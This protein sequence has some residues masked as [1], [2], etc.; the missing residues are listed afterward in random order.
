MNAELTRQLGDRPVPPNAATTTPSLLITMRPARAGSGNDINAGSPGSQ[1][2][3]TRSP[4]S[5]WRHSARI[6]EVQVRN[7]LAAGGED[8]EPSIPHLR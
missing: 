7:G 2:A 5:P 8:L 6:E 3:P 1:K 4:A